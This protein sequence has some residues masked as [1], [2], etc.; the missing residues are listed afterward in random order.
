VGERR[1]SPEAYRNAPDGRPILPHGP[2]GIGCVPSPIVGV[3]SGT[4]KTYKSLLLAVSSST[5][6]KPSEYMILKLP[7]FCDHRVFVKTLQNP[8]GAVVVGKNDAKDQKP[9]FSPSARTAQTNQAIS[10]DG[11]LRIFI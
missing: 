9:T 7:L 3:P 1:G 4:S 2:S 10:A 11:H 8:L 6:N 5:V